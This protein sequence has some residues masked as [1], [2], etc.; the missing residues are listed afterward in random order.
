MKKFLL[1]T[2]FIIVLLAGVGVVAYPFVSNY[3]NSLNSD[4]AV[5]QYLSFSEEADRDFGAVLESA[6]EYNKE[7]AK[8]SSVVSDPFS[9]SKNNNDDYMSQLSVEG[10]EVMATVEIKSL[11]VNLPIYHGTSEDVLEK[12]IGHL[13]TSSLPVGGVGTHAVITGHTGYSAMRLFTDINKLTTGDVFTI[14][15]CGEVL[16]YKVDNIAT[17]LPTETDLL[18]IDPD[19]DY[20]TMVTCTPFGV[21]SH[22]LLVRGVR[23]SNEEAEN[24]LSTQTSPKESTWTTEYLY[25]IIMGIIVMVLILVV[26]FSTKLIIR[27]CRKKKNE[28]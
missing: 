23:I 20:V 18:Q 6:H 9:A 21:N 7:L 28:Q 14:N 5:M 27:V 1:Y 13:S 12:G 4:S 22:R 19:Q 26:F 17:V 3:L 16:S 10:S 24:I 11:N 8:T 25:A 2:I 15:V